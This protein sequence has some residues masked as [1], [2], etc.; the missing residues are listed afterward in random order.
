MQNDNRSQRVGSEWVCL[1]LANTKENPTKFEWHD[2]KKRII[3]TH[4]EKKISS[5]LIR[6]LPMQLLFFGS[7]SLTN[8]K[9][10][11]SESPAPPTFCV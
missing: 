5:L 4:I 11:K 8:G 6:W 1:C 3:K 7:Q 2:E 9:Q 10:Q